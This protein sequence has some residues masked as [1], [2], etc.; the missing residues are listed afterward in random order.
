MIFE[1]SGVNICITCGEI[2]FK[3][4]FCNQDCKDEFMNFKGEAE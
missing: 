2:L 4:D 3:G 1:N